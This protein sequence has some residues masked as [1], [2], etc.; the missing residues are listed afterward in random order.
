MCAGSF[1]VMFMVA[2]LAVYGLLATLNQFLDLIPEFEIE[3]EVVV[4]CVHILFVIICCLS[5][6]CHH[7]N[8]YLISTKVAILSCMCTWTKQC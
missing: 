2:F 5:K 8:F 4:L 1:W 7:A 6:R 3:C